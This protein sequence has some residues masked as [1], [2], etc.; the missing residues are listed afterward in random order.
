GASAWPVRHPEAVCAT[1][2]LA[3]SNTEPIVSA[4]DCT[5]ARAYLQRSNA[6]PPARH[7]P[8]IFPAVANTI[9][10]LSTNSYWV[11]RTFQAAAASTFC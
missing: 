10:H 4:R 7:F 8:D 6:L 1:A 9:R 2:A 11:P 5:G 3:S